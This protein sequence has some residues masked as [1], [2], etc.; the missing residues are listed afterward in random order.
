MDILRDHP[1]YTDIIATLE[2]EYAV[3]INFNRASNTNSNLGCGRS[4]NEVFLG[5]EYGHNDPPPFKGALDRIFLSDDIRKWGEVGNLLD[6]S[7]DDCPK[8]AELLILISEQERDDIIQDIDDGLGNGQINTV[9][10]KISEV[11]NEL[12]IKIHE[13]INYSTI[14]GHSQALEDEAIS[15]LNDMFKNTKDLAYKIDDYDGSIDEILS[16]SDAASDGD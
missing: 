5:A 10:S 13:W 14:D 9:V 2:T 7:L 8:E 6:N 3:R 4:P 12:A 1:N 11:N 15:M 16:V